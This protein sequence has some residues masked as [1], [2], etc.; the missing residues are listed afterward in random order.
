M[1]L[2]WVNYDKAAAIS[3]HRLRVQTLY[4]LLLYLYGGGGGGVGMERVFEQRCICVAPAALTMGVFLTN[5]DGW[6]SSSFPFPA[7][8]IPCCQECRKWWQSTSCLWLLV[9]KTQTHWASRKP[10]Q[11]SFVHFSAVSFP[12]F[13]GRG[14]QTVNHCSA[15]LWLAESVGWEGHCVCFWRVLWELWEG[16]KDEG[17]LGCVFLSGEG[18]FDPFAH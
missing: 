17:V 18:C 3:R 8:V 7:P 1:V 15:S 12:V 11:V 6:A 5:A 2:V 14:V 16:L 4:T 10:I 9:W 13:Y